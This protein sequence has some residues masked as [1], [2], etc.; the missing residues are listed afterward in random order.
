MLNKFPAKLLASLI[1]CAGSTFVSGVNAQQF[2]TREIADN[3]LHAEQEQAVS[4]RTLV[5]DGNVRQMS[6]VPRL[7]PANTI[8]AQDEGL[9][10]T[11]RLGNQVQGLPQNGVNVASDDATNKPLPNPALGEFQS[12]LEYLGNATPEQIRAFKEYQFRIQGATITPVRSGLVG[13][14]S[15]YTVDL[16]P[17]ATAPVVRVSR[18]M[19]AT[20]NFVD[21]AGNPWPIKFANNFYAEA[22]QV[23][24]MAPHVLSVSS[25]SDH[26]TGSVGVILD[27]LS[28]PVNFVVTPAQEQTDYRV[29]LRIPGIAPNAPP[30]PGALSTQPALTTGNLMDFLYGATPQG[31]KRLSVSQ[32]NPGAG[33]STR[34]W[35]NGNGQLILRTDAQVISPGWYERLPAMDGTS[36]YALPSSPVIRVSI[37]GK[38]QTFNIEG[39]TPQIGA[40]AKK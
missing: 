5:S 37:Q 8:D 29:D 18:G 40:M 27:G 17:G 20:I 23:T 14:A 10:N 11:Q 2:Q 30:V 16:S 3:P 1:A 28:T 35:Q 31:A 24:Q 39:L 32:S 38:E 6:N 22:S 34:A 33:S 36:V 12:V 13:R 26:L 9:V 25:L 21:S 19:G 7:V 15:Q 4:Q